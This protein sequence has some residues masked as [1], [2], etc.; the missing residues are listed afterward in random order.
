ME[1][2]SSQI[3][4]TDEVRLEVAKSEIHEVNQRDSNSLC[5]L[6]NRMAMGEQSQKHILNKKQGTYDFEE[7]VLFSVGRV[8]IEEEDS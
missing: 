7:E 1:K 4:S 3:N 5:N 8:Q 2:E 6:P